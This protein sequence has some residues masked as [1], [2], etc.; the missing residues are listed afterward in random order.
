MAAVGS[1]SFKVLHVGFR[2]NK[3]YSLFYVQLQ[4]ATQ[5]LEVLK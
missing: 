2:K 3:N 1:P 5:L 4:V